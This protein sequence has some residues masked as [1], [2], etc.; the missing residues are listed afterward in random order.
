MSTMTMTAIKKLITGGGDAAWRPQDQREPLQPGRW[1]HGSIFFVLT[2]Q[3][4]I[5][6]EFIL[7]LHY[8]V[9]SVRCY[10]FFVAFTHCLCHR[11][12]GSCANDS[13]QARSHLTQL[14]VW[15][16]FF[17]RWPDFVYVEKILILF[18]NAADIRDRDDG[19]SPLM[20]AV[21]A[22]RLEVVRH[23][24]KTKTI[25]IVI[26]QPGKDQDVK[27]CHWSNSIVIMISVGHP[28]PGVV[29]WKTNLT[30]RVGNDGDNRF[31]SDVLN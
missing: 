2:F 17:Q 6:L 5:V 7:C 13:R 15:R 9:S 27:N 3:A 14:E 21:G 23:L 10:T 1:A 25:R 12:L 29:L 22:G 18:D 20:A 30:M 24:V 16:I 8:F 28:G 11:E 19:I 26:G 31:W 4:K